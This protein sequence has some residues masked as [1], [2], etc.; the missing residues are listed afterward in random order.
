MRAAVSVSGA[1]ACAGGAAHRVSRML[2]EEAAVAMVYN[3]GTQAVMMAT[4]ADLRDFAVGFS[5]SERIVE[6]PDEIESLEVAEQP[7]GIE[8]RMWLSG[9]RSEALARRRRFMAGPVGCG[10]CGID[11]L[12]E[13]LRPLPPVDGR[14]PGA[15]PRRD[16][17]GDRSARRL[18]A[19]ARRRPGRCMPPRSSFPA[20]A[21]W[22]PARTWAGTTRSTS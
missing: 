21:S 18:A 20:R 16:R 12:G 4:P 7:D 6:R 11:S 10:L 15:R 8:L 13:A 1:A 2:P 22:P 5:L 9:D 14:R 17:R 3:G 19:A